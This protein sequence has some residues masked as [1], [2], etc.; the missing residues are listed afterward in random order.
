MRAASFQ[1]FSDPS[2]WPALKGV[3]VLATSL[4]GF[5]GDWWWL[6][7]AVVVS[8]ISETPSRFVSLGH[9]DAL[10]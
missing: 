7:A 10:Q 9:R 5:T 2:H 6:G 3:V 4:G 8:S 1:T